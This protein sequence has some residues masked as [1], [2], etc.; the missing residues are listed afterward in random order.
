[1]RHFI[2]R[3]RAL[4][5]VFCIYALIECIFPYH[6]GGNLTVGHGFLAAVTIIAATF[7]HL[8]RRTWSPQQPS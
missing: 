7:R 1:M 8:L 4:I 6:I 5:L 3:H 2:G